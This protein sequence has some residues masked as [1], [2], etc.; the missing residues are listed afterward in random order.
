MD[1]PLPIMMTRY[2]IVHTY[3]VSVAAFCVG[4]SPVPGRCVLWTAARPK[5]Q[6]LKHTNPVSDGAGNLDHYA[7]KH[8]EHFALSRQETKTHISTMNTLHRQ[9]K[10]P[11]H[12]RTHIFMGQK[13]TPC[14]FWGRPLFQAK[15]NTDILQTVQTNQSAFHF[16]TQL[17]KQV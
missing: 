11:K 16:I 7:H 17:G 13:N 2:H 15:T 6:G 10:R 5:P 3:K 12:K 9:G 8:P 14:V 1:S 4:G